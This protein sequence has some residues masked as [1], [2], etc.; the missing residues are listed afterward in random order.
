MIDGTG[1]P[2]KKS[3]TILI[4]Y[5]KIKEVGNA[6]SVKIPEGF[7][8]LDM[9]GKTV[10]PGIIGTHNHM[11]FPRGP[12]FYTSPKLYLASGVTTIQTCG[13]GNPQEEMA[14]GKAIE[15][16]KIPGPE[17]VSSSPYFTGP[18]GKQNFIRFTNEKMV[19][20]T[21]RYL[22]S[23]GVQ[24]F[25]VYQHT[26]PED[27][28]VIINEVHKNGGKVTG[29]LCATTYE[30]AARLGIDAI[31]HGFI[32]SYDYAEGKEVGKCSGSRDFRSNMDISSEAVKRV[33]DILIEEGVALSTTPSIFEAQARGNADKRDLTALSPYYV[34]AYEDQ[35]KRMKEQGAAWYFKEVW[36]VKSLQYDLTFY[37]AGGLLTAGLDPGLHNVPG[38][39]DQKNYELFIEGGFKPEQAIQVM[40]LNGAKLLGKEE[41]G[42][43][44]KGKV[45]NLVVL[46]GNLEKD[47][48]VI[49]N[50]EIVFKEGVGFDSQKLIK[51]VQGLVGSAIDEKVFLGK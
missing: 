38:F 9:S 33:Q 4:E 44:E 41:I 28:R 15:E 19:R 14:I 1:T 24:W 29:H 40:T 10:I 32:H 50:V 48:S 51:S 25:K 11:R 13:T 18:E 47:A 12:L 22:T 2:L 21:I 26:R 8:Q 35:Q 49:R 42:S 23:I 20:D 5:G 27:L 30:E 3:Q 36:L 45:A 46:N 7:Y 37:K 39:G 16:G 17:I 34:A 43:I 31:E 6:T